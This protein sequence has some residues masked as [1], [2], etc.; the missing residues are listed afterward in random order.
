MLFFIG[1]HA[2]AET[3]NWAQATSNALTP[4]RGTTTVVFQNKIWAIGGQDSNG[5]LL[6]DVWSSSDGVNWT[7]V[8]ASASWSP[9]ADHTVVV[10]NNKMWLMGGSTISGTWMSGKANDVWYSSDGINWTQAVASAPWQ[11]RYRHTS[12]VFDNKIWVIGGGTNGGGWLNDIWYSSDGINWTQSTPSA[13]WTPRYCHSSVVYNGKMWVIGGNYAPGQNLNDVWY[14]SDGVNWTKATANAAWSPRD[15]QTT[16]S[17]NDGIFLLGGLSNGTNGTPQN[18]VWFSQDGINWNQITSST[19][20]SAR[21]GHNSEVF[22][23]KIWVIGGVSSTT[24]P[25]LNDVWFSSNLSVLPS[26]YDFGSVSV[27]SS[28]NPQSFIIT[29]NGTKN[30]TVGTISLGGDNSSEFE[31]KY[32]NTS[33]KTVVPGGS[34]IFNVIFSPNSEGLKNAILSISYTDAD[35][36]SEVINIS[37]TGKGIPEAENLLQVEIQTPPM[38]YINQEISLEAKPIAIET[39]RTAIAIISDGTA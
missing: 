9:R 25:C 2:N 22:N 39:G 5:N 29:N 36:N 6:N 35:S 28:S 18:D 3:I 17:F 11:G 27:G 31:I 15:F 1:S 4:A 7:Q 37:L 20:W 26:S 12:V 23:G 30:I 16:V 19:I 32:D 10:F 13:P 21:Y 33:G 38:C 14:S 24:G 8:T 34:T